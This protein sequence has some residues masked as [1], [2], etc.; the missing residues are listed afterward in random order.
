MASSEKNVS[1]GRSRRRTG[2]RAHSHASLVELVRAGVERFV[3]RDA[4]LMSFQK[5]I[6]TA[7]KKGEN[8]PHPLTGAAFR[9]IV[10][11]AIR[12]RKRRRDRAFRGPSTSSRE[13]S[14]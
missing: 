9:E 8:S 5:A 7:A 11:K 3:L 10:K 4:T 6:R 12:E 1:R 14:T 13:R 2:A